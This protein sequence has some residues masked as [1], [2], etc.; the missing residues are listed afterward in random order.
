MP[1]TTLEER[2]SYVADHLV[3][4]TGLNERPL[5]PAWPGLERFPGEVL[6]SSAY[7]NGAPFEGRQV[8]VV[9][10]GSSG[11]EIAVDLVEHGVRVALAVRSP[12]NVVPRRMLGRPVEEVAT[13][14]ERLPVPVSD[15]I[16]RAVRRLRFGDMTRHGLRFAPLSPTRQVNERARIP[17]IDIGTVGHVRAGRITVH[18]GPD[19]FEGERA[20]FVDGKE[21]PVDAVV[22]ATG[23]RVG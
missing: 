19:R 11:G 7:R 14:L 3:I 16:G 6:H 15:A 2:G 10:F 23:Y 1:T 21:L 12:V 5:R 22:L 20:V 18:P 4:A 9:G 8:L 13:L 17:L